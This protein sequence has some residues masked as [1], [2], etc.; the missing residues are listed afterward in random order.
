LMLSKNK[1]IYENRILKEHEEQ[2]L[3][4]SDEYNLYETTL[5]KLKIKL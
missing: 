3:H 4:K 1:I 5:S 2:I